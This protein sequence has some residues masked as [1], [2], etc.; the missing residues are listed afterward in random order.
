MSVFI[1]PKSNRITDAIKAVLVVPES[2]L[3][4]FNKQRLKK[5]ESYQPSIPAFTC[6]DTGISS[7]SFLR[8]SAISCQ[9]TLSN[10]DP[11]KSLYTLASSA[12]GL[13]S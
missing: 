1:S 9:L 2:Q 13:N 12:N 10:A 3:I 7:A 11:N 8:A 6:Y 4:L 5:I